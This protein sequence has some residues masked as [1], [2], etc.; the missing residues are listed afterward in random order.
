MLICHV[1]CEVVERTLFEINNGH[2]PASNVL[3]EQR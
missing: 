3:V 1:M 2:R